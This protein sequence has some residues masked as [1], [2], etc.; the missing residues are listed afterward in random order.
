MTHANWLQGSD[1]RRALVIVTGAVW[2]FF[3]VPLPRSLD[4][5]GMPLTLALLLLDVVLGAL[6]GW[7]AFARTASLDERQAALRDRAYRL[8]FRLILLGVIVMVLGAI[9]GSIADNSGTPIQPADVFGSRWIIGL[10]ELL[11]ALPTVVI[12]W[13]QPGSVEEAESP[14]RLS[15]SRWLPL[16][17]VPL[18][19][20]LWLVAIAALPVEA[21]AVRDD[22]KHG[23][24]SANETCGHFTGTRD[25]GYGFGAE[26]RLD[27]ETC[28][29][30]N[31]AY[32]FRKD[33]YADLTRCSVE[34]GTADFARVRKLACTET[35]DADGTMHY[36]VQA[37]VQSGLLSTVTRNVVLELDVTRDGTVL[38]F[39]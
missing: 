19:A 15:P 3:A 2:G 10:L 8:A 22:A 1:I 6:T 21:S 16:I 7:L 11:A 24:L 23:L 38:S 26:V 30:G 34:P 28:W 33:I 12:A 36:Q 32:A 5:A 18:L 29:D 37:T 17:A 35:T 25:V 14:S 20:A 27:V 31:R 13:L 4:G 39:G 9:A